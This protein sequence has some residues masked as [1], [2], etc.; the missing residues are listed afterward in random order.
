M[1]RSGA[2]AQSAQVEGST[3][4]L[5]RSRKAHVGPIR[6]CGIGVVGVAGEVV[7][8]DVVPTVEEDAL[9]VITQRGLS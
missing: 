3:L 6:S 1:E 7:F 4:S 8:V 9:L 2:G 5:V